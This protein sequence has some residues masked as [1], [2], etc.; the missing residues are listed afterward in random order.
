LTTTG[1][2][3]GFGTGFAVWSDAGRRSDHV[4]HRKTAGD[5]LAC[6]RNLPAGVQETRT[7]RNAARLCGAAR[8][9]PPGGADLDPAA[10][11]RASLMSAL[12]PRS[13]PWRGVAQP[14]SLVSDGRHAATGAITFPQGPIWGSGGGWRGAVS[15]AD[16]TNTDG[17]DRGVHHRRPRVGSFGWNSDAGRAG[18][19]PVDIRLAVRQ[20]TSSTPAQPGG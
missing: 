5:P 16:V 11:T 19:S 7:G 1:R 10:Q 17:A 3:F 15:G 12:A 2:G 8:A 9:P 13:Q 4:P 6:I 18:L 14:A 20:G